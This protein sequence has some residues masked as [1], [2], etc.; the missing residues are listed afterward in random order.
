MTIE[1]HLTGDLVTVRGI[2]VPAA[3]NEN[4]DV[5]AVAISAIGEEEYLV[6]GSEKQDELWNLIQEEIEV[7]GVVTE[8]AGGNKGIV[9]LRYSVPRATAT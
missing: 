6:D 4:G 5:T 8:K 7:T 9:V 2:V 1:Y 3:W